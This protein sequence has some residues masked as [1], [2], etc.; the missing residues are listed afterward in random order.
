MKDARRLYTLIGGTVSPYYGAV[1]AMLF[2]PNGGYRGLCHHHKT[3]QEAIDC[4]K[5]RELP[6]LVQVLPY[7]RKERVVV[8]PDHGEVEPYDAFV[9]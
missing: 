3:L 8:L 6:A 1:E 2:T 9:D 4:E 5:G 7:P